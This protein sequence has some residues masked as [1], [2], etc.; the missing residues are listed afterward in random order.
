MQFQ[1]DSEEDT[2]Q[3]YTTPALQKAGWDSF[4]IL[5][6]YNLN[7]D[8]KRIVPGKNRTRND[9]SKRAK[10]DYLL[11]HGVNFPIAVVEAKKGSFP[12]SEG[13]DQ[14]IAYAEKLDIPFAYASAGHGFVEYNLKTGNQRTLSLDEFP[15]PESLWRQ[16]CELRAVADEDIETLSNATYHTDGNRVPRYYQLQAI[17]KTVNAI[18]ADKR[19]RALIVMAT[20]TG[21]TYTAFQIVW[22]L[23]KAKVIK[24]VLYLADRNQLIDQTMRDDFKPFKSEK[25]M[26]KIQHGEVNRNLEIYFGLY[27]QLAGVSEETD[28]IESETVKLVEHYRDVPQ[29][30]FD[31]IIVD[32][33]H[34][35]SA[36]EDSSWR[37]ILDHFASAIQIGMTATPYK[38]QKEDDEAVKDNLSYFGEPLYTYSLKQGIDDGYLAP[39]QVVQV[40]FDK[41]IEGWTPEPGEC[42]DNGLL[43]P[44]RTYRLSDFGTRLEL[45]ERTKAVAKTVTEYLQHIGPMSKT[46][47]FCTTQRHALAMR[48]AMRSYNTEMQKKNSRYIVRMTADDQEGKAQYEA[49]T[50]VLEVYPVVVT[51]SKLLTTG[52]NTQTVKLI[53]L[54]S[55]IRSMTE[56]KQI[57]GR[58]TRLREDEGKTMFTIL[59]FRNACA[60]FA[61]PEFDGEPDAIAEWK[62]ADPTGQNKPV[63]PPET[64]PLHPDGN[65]GDN[66]ENSGDDIGVREPEPVYEVSHVTV[67]KKGEIQKFLD[68]DGRLITTKYID[69]TRQNILKLFG[70]DAQFI[71]VWNGEQEKQSVS[72]KL[73]EAGIDIKELAKELGNPDLD[74]FDMVRQIAF[75]QPPTTKLL[76]ANK[77]R[78]SRFFEK[79]QAEARAVLE[80]LLDIYAKEGVAEID[81]VEVLKRKELE[82]FGGT[83]KVVNGLFGGKEAYRSAIREMEGL[84]YPDRPAETAIPL[85]A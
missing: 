11:C 26:D 39:Y 7:S 14:A 45:K 34:R 46:I 74:V 8:R 25:I 18:I 61:D 71:E 4:S 23:R 15:S 80:R 24:T 53:V 12:D 49:F 28:A 6:E 72:R 38:V 42:D 47:I 73:E 56:F 52:A 19:K 75:G 3:K 69:F 43:I 81:T 22:R 83:V 62:A 57:I 82:E 64:R 30:Y 40:T 77:V 13:L 51:T 31:L 17:N 58:G 16:W 9:A 2:K 44:Q 54:D 48:D 32:E 33:C 36:K 63:P 59:D 67:S 21:K 76:R 60:L 55:N 41:D 70:S 85:N 35:G 5:M 84:L 27:Q 68:E 66:N 29:D 37:A 50:S 78:Q 10:P 1:S 20:G 65:S 79:Y